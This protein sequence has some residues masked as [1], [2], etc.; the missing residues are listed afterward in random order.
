MH[1]LVGQRVAIYFDTKT[2][3]GQKFVAGTEFKVQGLE[4]SYGR[5]LLVL[6]AADG[7]RLKCAR[8][9]VRV[10]PPPHVR[11]GNCFYPKRRARADVC[12]E[13]DEP[14]GECSTCPRCPICDK[15]ASS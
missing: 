6:V 4:R 12:L 14:R 11:G 7:R 8:G 5:K 15:E 13:H 9:C 10:L 1:E 3:G 2:H